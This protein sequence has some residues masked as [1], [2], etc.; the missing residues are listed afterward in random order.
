M[1]N[2]SYRKLKSADSLILFSCLNFLPKIKDFTRGK[3]NTDKEAIR[4]ALQGNSTKIIDPTTE[5]GGFVL[6]GIYLL[7]E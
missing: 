1:L 7:K 5:I 3:I 4:W 2:L 6:E